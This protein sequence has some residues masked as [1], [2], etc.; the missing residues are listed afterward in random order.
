[1]NL[2][3]NASPLDPEQGIKLLL[4]EEGEETVIQKIAQAL[5]DEIQPGEIIPET[6]SGY[7]LLVRDALEFFL[8][9][10]PLPVLIDTCKQ[11]I[12]KSGALPTKQ[13][14]AFL[15]ARRFPTLQK[16]CQTL[17]RNKHLDPAVKKWLVQLES[18]HDRDLE[19]EVLKK[20]QE[21]LE[22]IGRSEDIAFD[23]VL[24][25]ASVAAV[26]TC[27][28]RKQEDG[29]PAPFVIKI[30]KPR[31]RQ[32]LERELEILG[33]LADHIEATKGGYGLRQ[34]HVRQLFDDLREIFA[35]EVNMRGE[36]H[37]LQLAR[38]RYRKAI[39]IHIPRTEPIHSEVMTGME[40]APGKKVTEAQLSSTQ[41]KEAAAR[42]CDALI[43][44]VIF[45]NKSESIFHGD[46]HAGNILAHPQEDTDVVQLSLL[47][48]S[49]A[50]ILGIRER[51]ALVRLIIAIAANDTVSITT[52]V[53][54]LA[55]ISGHLQATAQKKWHAI[56]SDLCVKKE[57][58]KAS[59]VRKS[60]W[61]VEELSFSGLIFSVEFLLFRKAIFTLE[62]VLHDL[63]RDFDLDARMMH[64]LSRLLW[65]ETPERIRK[66][67]VF[68]TE[69]AED[70]ASLITTAELQQLSFTLSMQLALKA[71]QPLFWAMP[72]LR[73]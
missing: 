5:A 23:K 59:L 20:L 54:D 31:I 72:V 55:N 34:L 46:P 16:L 11:L 63:D 57:F 28:W 47:D 3:N 45:S 15:L 69:Q 10:Q 70:Y 64:Y 41:R 56:I 14:L 13:Q 44:D 43:C 18:G 35:A 39:G 50:G 25:E 1:M 67:M 49:L 22:K 19:P 7:R 2:F 21:E 12:Q 65:E 71:W 26:I 9:R 36:R 62:G 24:A 29:E 73:T 6:F 8:S 68:A 27:S 53:I 60:L 42:L 48:W 4:Q 40:F 17:A 52:M 38:E 32:Q 66:S 58:T 33:E 37:Y 30:L 61:L 51:V